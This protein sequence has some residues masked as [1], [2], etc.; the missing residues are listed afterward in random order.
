MFLL[1]PD[2]GMIPETLPVFVAFQLTVAATGEVVRVI[3]VLLPEQIIDAS[4]GLV[5]VTGGVT[6][7]WAETT[8]PAIPP[9]HGVIQYVIMWFA[10]LEF[11]STC[12]IRLPEP[13]AW[14]ETDAGPVTVHVN[15][16]PGT[17]ELR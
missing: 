12:D 16:A 13:G 8:G 9:Y 3:L 15:V 5:S 2:V 14:P 4:E 1:V 7:T 11:T 17:L 10:I 6:S